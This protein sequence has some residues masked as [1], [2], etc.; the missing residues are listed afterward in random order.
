MEFINLIIEEAFLRH[1]VLGGLLAS[2]VCGLIGPF[3]VTKRIGYMGGG[4]AHSVLGGMGAAYFVGASPVTGALIA[5][6]VSA[7]V[8][9]MISRKGQQSED[10]AISAVWTTGM[11]IG[12]I[13]MAKTP[14]YNVDLTTY[15][16]GNILMIPTQGLETIA[17]IAV[18]IF[19]VIVL[20]YKSFI[21]VTFDEEFARL[22]GVNVTLVNLTL[23]CMVGLAVV[24]LMQLVGIIM[25]IA[26][27]TLP[28][29]AASRISQKFPVV[30]IL[31][32]FIG[33]TSSL[34]GLYLAFVFDVPAGATIILCTVAIF[35]A[36]TISRQLSN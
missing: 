19:L 25:V 22:R 9:G 34:L 15:L 13:F 3:V 16:F 23:L 18:I 29:A 4:I 10:T 5:A 36:I 35:S 6:I 26:L 17:A 33:S 31:S 1:A 32:F 28:A 2:L 11:A 24:S 7:L 20:R 30:M 8:I 12:L 21:A 27:L 14:G